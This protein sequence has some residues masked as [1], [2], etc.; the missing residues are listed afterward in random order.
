MNNN[1]KD[2]QNN[3]IIKALLHLTIINDLVK[4]INN[5]KIKILKE[6]YI[7]YFKDKHNNITYNEFQS[8]IFK[9]IRSK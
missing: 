6:I 9:K 7:K 8:N 1:N 2:E 4:Q 3:N 5:K